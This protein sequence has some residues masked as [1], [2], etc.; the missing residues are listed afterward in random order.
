MSVG[1]TY[2]TEEIEWLR[3]NAPGKLRKDL[4]T[5][6]NKRFDTD[7]SFNQLCGT[8]KRYQIRNGVNGQF[9]KGHIP[10][11]KGKK[12]ITL[13]GRE[14]QFKKGNMP[15][16]HLPVGTERIA[17]NDYIQVK[18]AEPKTWKGKHVVIWE[19]VN[20]PVPE[21]HVVIFGDGNKRNFDLDNLILVSKKQLMAMNTNGLIQDNAELTRTAIIVADLYLKIG[22]MKRKRS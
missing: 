12:G 5:M 9:Q 1:H 4:L 2:S 14:T 13:G 19:Q 21:G 20:G 15:H 10:Y 22:E 8:M 7:I 17:F 16:N 6:F 3:V 11:T 18:V